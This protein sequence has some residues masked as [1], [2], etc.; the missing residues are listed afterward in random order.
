MDQIWHSTVFDQRKS[1]LVALQKLASAKRKT[2]A[3]SS[4]LKKRKNST[5]SIKISSSKNKSR[6]KKTKD[7]SETSQKYSREKFLFE[8]TKAESTDSNSGQKTDVSSL[9]KARRPKC[10]LFHPLR[11]P[12]ISKLRRMSSH[13]SETCN[14][15]GNLGIHRWQEGDM[16]WG[17]IRGYP[18]WPC[19]VSKDPFT[20]QFTKVVGKHQQIVLSVH[21]L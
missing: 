5:I 18:F 13:K 7:S 1:K 12:S 2:G 8:K 6:N 16:L 9:A 15:D 19:M 17:K 3:E 14:Q 10:V 21:S 11:I 20:K 4:R